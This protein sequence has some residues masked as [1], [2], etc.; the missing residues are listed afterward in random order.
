MKR[1]WQYAMSMEEETMQKVMLLIQV[2]LAPQILLAQSAFDGTWRVKLDQF[3]Y[4]GNDTYLLAN[5]VYR[6]GT[7]EPKI[8][9]KADGQDHKLTGSAYFDTISVRVV[10]EATVETIFKKAGK[11]VS[12]WKKT[13]SEDGNT[14][15]TEYTS[16]TENGQ[17]TSGRFNS[18]RVG[19]T[20]QGAHRI[21]GSWHVAKIESASEN[22]MTLTFKE[23]DGGL[24]MTQPAG[25]AYTAQFDGKDYPYKGDP[26]TTSVSLKKINANT[27]EETDKRGGKVVGVA[28]MTVAA[29]GKTMALSFDN[30]LSGHTVE[31]ALEKQ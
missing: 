7:C 18:E 27:I 3:Q 12:T 1:C 19:P 22:I 25:Q 20:P 21:S 9:V 24:S 10:N 4:G 26:G 14:L 30:K 8:K 13:A 15:T 6:C 2:I 31:F 23:T 5:G 28:R 29:D 17:Q 11:V 16:V